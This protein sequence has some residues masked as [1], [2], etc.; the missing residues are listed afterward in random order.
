MIMKFENRCLS[1]V[2]GKEL[3]QTCGGLYSII[4]NSWALK[5]HLQATVRKLAA[6]IIDRACT[7]VCSAT[8]PL[9]QLLLEMNIAVFMHGSSL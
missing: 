1:S 6:L 9:L 4:T 8:Q 3:Y 5:M 2:I 7:G